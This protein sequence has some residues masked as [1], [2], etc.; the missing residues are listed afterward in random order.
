VPRDRWS[1]LRV[2]ARADHLVVQWNGQQVIDA[3]DPTFP[4]AG[5]VG[6]WTKADSVT[7][8]DDLTVAPADQN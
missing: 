3:R 6:V 7:A 1:E 5:R 8:F 4:E 2:D